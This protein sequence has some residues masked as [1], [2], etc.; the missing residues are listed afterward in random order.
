MPLRTQSSE[1]ELN[2][3]GVTAS[4]QLN[5]TPSVAECSDKSELSCNVEGIAN[6]GVKGEFWEEDRELLDVAD[7]S[8]NWPPR[9]SWTSS[10]KKKARRVKHINFYI[11]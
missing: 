3:V 4:T 2:S 8:R 6:T 10:R 9:L 7:E 11:H 1:E 5:S